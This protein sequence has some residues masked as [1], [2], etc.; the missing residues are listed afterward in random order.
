MAG[1][2]LVG[3][4]GRIDF[5]LDGLTFR[6]TASAAAARG[7]ERLHHVGWASIEQADV[8]RSPKGKTVVQVVVSDSSIAPSGKRDPY[9]L[10][11]KRKSADDAREFAAMINHEVSARRR[12]EAAA[13]DL[14]DDPQVPAP[15]SE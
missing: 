3:T 15:P 6:R 5:T 1:K 12:W 11:I 13:D 8:T 4:N 2:H 7:V 9:A 14:V 10:K